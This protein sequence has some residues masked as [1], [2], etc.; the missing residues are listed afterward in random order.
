MSRSGPVSPEPWRRRLC[1]VL[2]LGLCAMIGLVA[3]SQVRQ[4]SVAA[5]DPSAQEWYR[6]RTCESGNDYSI[7]T[8]NDHY[9]AYQFDL[10]TWR[11]M[12]GSGYPDLAPPGEQDARALMLYRMRGWQPWQCASILGL[13]EDSDA[14]SGRISDIAIPDGTHPA[15]PGSY[16]STGDHG[17]GIRQWQLQMR[18][19]GA[20]LGGTGRFGPKTLA[21]VE[22]V[23]RVNHL[24]VT[25]I[26]GPA[27]WELAWT[28]RY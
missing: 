24:R 23:Q 15:W 10:S 25:G 16:Y 7:D 4:T 6:L 22:R 8:G 1:R 3:I 20:P 28:G 17:A 14:R 13:R 26:L 27:T 9:G 19:R 18:H 11:D 12:G 21:V 5:A 2:G